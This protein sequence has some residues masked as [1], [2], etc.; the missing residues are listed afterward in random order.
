MVLKI[1]EIRIDKKI[2]GIAE[3]RDESDKDAN[4]RI[5]IDLKA[6][7]NKELVMNY[8]LKNTEDVKLF[9]IRGKIVFARTSNDVFLMSNVS[10]DDRDDSQQTW[11]SIDY[12]HIVE[13][14]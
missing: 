8:L 4:L 11:S 13:I 12:R 1:D 9:F 7:A 3:V 14:V 5:V 2:D 10:I 6:G